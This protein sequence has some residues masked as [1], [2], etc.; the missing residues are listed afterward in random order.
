MNQYGKTSHI[1]FGNPDF[2][3]LAESFGATGFRVERAEDLPE[4][5]RKAL[6]VE[7][8]V[9][10]DC[11]VD[12]SENMKLSRRLGE[13]PN[14]ERSA[15]LKKSPVF[16][17]VSTEYL[18]IIGDY[19]EQRSYSPGEV[20]CEQG[21]AGD[22]VFLLTKGEVEV[23]IERDG[24]AEVHKVGPGACFGEMAVLADQPRSATVVAAAGG[25]EALVLTA[26]EFQEIL[27]SQPVI[28][29]QLLKVVT[30][31]LLARS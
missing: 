13:I 22:E 26:S 8:P 30:S 4:I 16:S 25:V 28:G 14:S 19:M 11:P 31:R 6:A 2:V 29:V 12:Y 1:A 23:R 20:I 27:I 21:S 5:L 3:K 9:V 18:E 17:G 24:K 7:G 15:L 10:I